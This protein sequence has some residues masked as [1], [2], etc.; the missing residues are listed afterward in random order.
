MSAFR[1]THM[2]KSLSK[3]IQ[4]AGK[5]LFSA[6]A[7]RRTDF[8]HTVIGAG[9]VGLCIARRLQR[10]DGTSVLLLDR[11][12][13]TGTETS[14]RNSEVIHGALYYGHGSLKTKL[15]LRGKNALYDFCERT[16]V[17]IKRTGKW[18]VAQNEEQLAALNNIDK[19][20]KEVGDGTGEDGLGGQWGRGFRGCGLREDER[21]IPMRWLTKEEAK[22]R[23]PHVRAEAGALE[24][25]S[26]GI[27]DSH[28][29]MQALLGEFEEAGGTVALGSDVLSIHNECDQWRV[30]S[31]DSSAN[32]VQFRVDQKVTPFQCPDPEAEG[33]TDTTTETLVNSAGLAAM[34][35]SNAIL[36]R[37]CHREP[38]YAKGTYFSYSLSK[39]KS[40]TLIYPAPVPGHGGLGTHLTLDMAGRLRFGPDVE[41][42]DDPSDLKPNQDP[43]R[44]RAALDDIQSYLPGLDRD[45]VA[46]D[47]CGVRPKLSKGGSATSGKS[48]EDFYIQR[49][50]DKLLL[51]APFVNLLGIESP[52]LTSSLAI[53]EYVHELLYR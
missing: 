10:Q 31:R 24:S 38:A 2:D 49:D 15:C 13:M 47:Y 11:H 30:W 53:G 7:S 42:V 35:L 36:P 27:V 16:G 20:A 8:T 3:N 5:R 9:A 52:G 25:S 29:Y 26:T 45:A 40:S 44:F 12:T 28:S 14:S 39:P 6:S 33:A 34:S 32:D 18:I 51:G 17:P 37:K 50:E 48:F 46:L 22:Q 4:R 23:E 19:F 43:E 1:S 41:W 21:A